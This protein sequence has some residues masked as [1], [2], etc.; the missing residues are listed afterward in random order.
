MPLLLGGPRQSDSD[1]E[2]SVASTPCCHTCSTVAMT[3]FPFMSSLRLESNVYAIVFKTGTRVLR[4]EFIILNTYVEKEKRSQ[5]NSLTS[6][7]KTLRK[8]K[9]LTQS[10]QKGGNNE[11]ER[12]L[13]KQRI[14][15]TK[16]K[17]KKT[18]NWF[19][20][21]SIRLDQLFTGLTKNKRE[22]NNI[23]KIRNVREDITI[24]L[25]K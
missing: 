1:S 20:P 9:K 7:L 12:N 3:Q 24:N 23:T 22:K 16:E 25:Q 2:K 6:H 11:L 8:K 15:K 13:M 4:G 10:K 19:F 14:K 21:K 5:I 18:E 17:I